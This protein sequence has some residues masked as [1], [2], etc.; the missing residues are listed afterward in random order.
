MFTN[1]SDN[2]VVNFVLWLIVPIFSLII[3]IVVT[4]HYSSE[5]YDRVFIGF[6][7]VINVGIHIYC[8]L[9][10][11]KYREMVAMVLIFMYNLPWIVAVSV[12]YFPG[13]YFVCS[14]LFLVTGITIFKIIMEFKD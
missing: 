3:G 10:V 11:L 8:Y 1:N 5:E 9:K 12:D 14:T 2:E 7:G 4:Y 6:S 13:L